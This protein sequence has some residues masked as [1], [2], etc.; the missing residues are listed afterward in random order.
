MQTTGNGARPGVT[1][2]KGQCLN[3]INVLSF[4]L[5]EI[6]TSVSGG[7]R[8]L[9]LCRD[10]ESFENYYRKITGRKLEIIFNSSHAN[11]HFAAEQ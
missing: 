2:V 3:I 11:W 10:G 9:S 8:Y 6:F 1:S 4:S 7:P 5:L